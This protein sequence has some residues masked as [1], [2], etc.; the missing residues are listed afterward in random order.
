MFLQD[1]H[2]FTISKYTFNQAIVEWEFTKHAKFLDTPE[3]RTGISMC[4]YHSALDD[5]K[6]IHVLQDK[7]IVEVNTDDICLYRCC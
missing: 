2:D 4:C 3:L 6:I 7:G 5:S 1:E